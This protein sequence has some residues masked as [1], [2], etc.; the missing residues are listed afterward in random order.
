M[1]YHYQ[2]TTPQAPNSKGTPKATKAL[3]II[4]NKA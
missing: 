2:Q 3:K 4:Y 1:I